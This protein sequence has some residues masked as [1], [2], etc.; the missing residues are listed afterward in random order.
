MVVALCRAGTSPSCPRS[1]VP[2]VRMTRRRRRGRQP[3]RLLLSRWHL[4]FPQRRSRGR[5]RHRREEGL[6]PADSGEAFWPPSQ[7]PLLPTNKPTVT[8]DASGKT[9]EAAITLMGV[10]NGFA[11]NEDAISP[12][13]LTFARIRGSPL[14]EFF[15]DL[16]SLLKEF[17]GLSHF[18]NEIGIAA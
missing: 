9:L 16:Q 6:A 17:K 11:W 18:S 7:P 8:S 1:T 12:T 13:K 10:V 5:C 2:T 3:G 14:A 15:C 4:L